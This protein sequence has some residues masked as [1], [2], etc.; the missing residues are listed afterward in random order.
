MEFPHGEG[1]TPTRRN[2]L[3]SRVPRQ[4]SS[5]GKDVMGTIHESR[6]WEVRMKYAR[7]CAIVLL[8]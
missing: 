7:Y 1:V 4:A 6:T 5:V 2:A 3:V 8:Y